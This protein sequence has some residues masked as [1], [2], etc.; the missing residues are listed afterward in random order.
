MASGG[1][2]SIT[3]THLEGGVDSSPV[4]QSVDLPEIPVYTSAPSDSVSDI[5]GTVRP[6]RSGKS[7]AFSL[8]EPVRSIEVW[9]DDVLTSMQH[10][11]IEMGF[12]FNI[13]NSGGVSDFEGYV[14]NGSAATSSTTVNVNATLRSNRPRLLKRHISLLSVETDYQKRKHA[15]RWRNY[16]SRVQTIPSTGPGSASHSPRGER[17]ALF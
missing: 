16:L 1:L 10:D 4:S 11:P 6:R 13:N 9:R 8:E 15:K 5:N 14:L 7:V 2:S 12:S 3:E 17:L